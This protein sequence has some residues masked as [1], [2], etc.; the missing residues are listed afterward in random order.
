MAPFSLSA[1]RRVQ[2]VELARA[3]GSRRLGHR[4][5]PPSPCRRRQ[6]LSSRRLQAHAQRDLDNARL[7]DRASDLDERRARVVVVADIGKGARAVGHDP[8]HERESLDVVDDGRSAVEA[9]LG[10]I[11]RPLIGLRALVLDRLEQ[12]RLLAD[13]HAAGQR[14]DLDVD[15]DARAQGVRADVALLLGQ[16]HDGFEPL[17]GQRRA[18]TQRDVRAARADGVRGEGQPLDD[19]VRIVLHQGSI[20]ARARICLEA[21]GHDVALVGGLSGRGAPLGAG[22]ISATAAAAQAG[23]SDDAHERRRIGRADGLLP[24]LPCAGLFGRGQSAIGLRTCRSARSGS[25]AALGSWQ[26]FIGVPCLRPRRPRALGAQ[27]SRPAAVPCRRS[28]PAAAG[29]RVSR[30]ARRG[31]PRRNRPATKRTWP[32]AVTPPMSVPSAATSASRIRPEPSS[33]H[34]A[35]LAQADLGVAAGLENEARVRRGDAVDLA[36]PRAGRVADV[37]QRRDGQVAV[38][39]LRPLED[40]QQPARVVVVGRPGCSRAAQGRSAARPRRS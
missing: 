20:E 36:V 30:E 40:G 10:G 15:V 39:R 21:V 32:S 19:G 3:A 13:D 17:P 22:R 38:L 31:S 23:V 18:L 14:H 24:R 35:Q 9:L 16:A 28:C 4:R 27:R 25:W 6:R 7:V 2:R 1:V 5:A 29:H 33:A 26:S 12:N 11:R 34:V 8:G 37:L